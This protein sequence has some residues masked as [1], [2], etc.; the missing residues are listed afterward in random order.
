M[1]APCAR[2]ALTTSRCFSATAHIRAVW[3]CPVS[4]A[5]TFAPAESSAFTTA[6]LPVCAA[7]ISGVSPVPRAALGSACAVNRASTIA[8][9]P[10]GHAKVVCRVHI[11]APTE[12]QPRHFEIVPVSGPVQRGGAIRLP[13]IHIGALFEQFAHGCAVALLGRFRHS[14]I[15]AG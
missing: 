11:G 14:S 2:S 12:E 15:G 13:P 9:L 8:R 6:R 5:F 3:P 7:V 10:W 4:S 1:S